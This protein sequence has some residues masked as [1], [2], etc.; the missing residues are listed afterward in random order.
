MTAEPETLEKLEGTVE[1]IIFANEANGYTVCELDALSGEPHVLVG[2][3]PYLA[4]GE[5]IQAL[6]KFVVHPTFGRQFK[7][8]TY[9][10]QLPATESAIL[11]YLASG[12]VKGIGPITAKKIVETYMLD[13]FDVM[14]NHPEWL[15]DI[16]G[17]SP[18]KAKEIGDAFREQAGMRNVMM[19][20]NEFFGPALSVRI[21][22]ELGAG[23][24]EM[25]KE[26][27]YVLC[28]RISGIG[29]EKA[30]AVARRVG[31]SKQ[32][33][34]RIAF[35]IK[36]VMTYNAA[37]NGHVYL[38]LHKL[39]PTAD[40]LL[41]CGEENI[42]KVLKKR[43]E[44]G[45][46]VI[47]DIDRFKCVYTSEMYQKE[48]YI[49]KKLIALESVAHI[50]PLKDLDVL[51]ERTELE[52]GL[53][54]ESLQRRAIYGAVNNSVFLLTGGPGTGKT[55]VVRAILRIFETLG[56]DIALCA[57]TGR[58]AKRLSQ[59]SGTEA[60]TIHRL[61]EMEYVENG[62]LDFFRNETN[63]LE[64]DVVIVDEASMV[65]IDV[66]YAL[67]SAMKK[68]ARLVLIGDANQLPPVGAGYIFSDILASDRFTS[69][70]LNRI[71]RQAEESYIVVN[72]HT[73]NRGEY[74]DLSHKDS[75]FF[76]LRREN[77]EDTAKTVVELCASRLPK[78]YKMTVYDGIQ[79][80]SPSHK[81]EAGTEM[82]N[83]RLQSA[84]NPPSPKKRQA[85]LPRTLFREGD[86]V[87]QIKNNYEI[88]F[89]RDG[90]AGMG[91]FNGEIGIIKKI[92]PE[93]EKIVVDFDGK[94]TTYDY[95]S[96]E[97]LE[98]AYAVTVHKSQGSEYPIVVIPLYR[99]TPR[100]LTRNLLY[101]AVTRAQA[102]IVLVGDEEVS[103]AMIDNDRRVKRY[104]G[105]RQLLENYEDN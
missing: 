41:A 13:T 99:Y 72:A 33:E 43:V 60:K 29:F 91:I 85:K 62:T 93:E 92:D 84:I 10:R 34:D 78:R 18:K 53:K 74:L 9:E 1:R 103:K 40:K 30:D 86:K 38:P 56:L 87:M 50:V 79:V 96:A 19:F 94:I 63:P 35:G 90:A 59:L 26:N 69:V 17:V 11:K 61:L 27:P 66:M 67:L 7:V 45:M 14:E 58:A 46:F 44:S 15:A 5:T 3:M 39:V 73:I 16:A 21:Y 2:I 88:P 68:S 105:L 89:V 101:T 25:I 98:L 22:K 95:A 49:A 48:T 82:L 28:E 8:E 42:L 83:A 76:F 4:E 80:V 65:D 52:N 70:V 64:S 97:E 54:Y 102:M 20:C 57:P 81:G 55:T 36:Y 23:A 77:D 100:L 32:S 47:K 24:V 6:G 51:I 75:D 104:T 37:E 31:L 71:F 12:I